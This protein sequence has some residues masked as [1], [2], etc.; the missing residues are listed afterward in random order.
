MGTTKNILVVGIKM[1]YKIRKDL[2]HP[3]IAKLYKIEALKSFANVKK[4]DLGGFIEK[5]ENLSQEDNCWV[6]EDAHVCGDAQVYG[7]ARVSGKALVCGNAQVHWN[8]WVYDKLM[9]ADNIAI[10]NTNTGLY[11]SYM[12]SRGVLR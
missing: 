11:F 4:G 7:N 3:T 2:P 6:Y 8:A 1:K 5:E 12:Y 9:F 10:Q